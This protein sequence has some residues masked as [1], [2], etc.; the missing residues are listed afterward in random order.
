MLEVK[1]REPAGSSRHWEP[2]AQETERSYMG[3]ADGIQA[4]KGG[5]MNEGG[6]IRMEMN[7][8]LREKKGLLCHWTDS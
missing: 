1:E 6:G 2:Q 5:G 3:S 4:Q 8:Q 7:G